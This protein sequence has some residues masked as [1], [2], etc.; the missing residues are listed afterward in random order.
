MK[1]GNKGFGNYGENLAKVFLEGLGY[2]FI[3]ANYRNRFGEIDLIFLDGDVLVL[4][5]VKIRRKE[6]AA[7]LEDTI[8][9]SKIKKILKCAEIFIEGSVVGYKEMRIDAVLILEGSGAQRIDHYKDI[10]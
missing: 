4:T 2:R 9:L 7:T 5:E 6:S 3:A 1:S 8:P 10:Y